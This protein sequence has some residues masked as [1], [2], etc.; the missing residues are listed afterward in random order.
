MADLAGR[1]N[2]ELRR[3]DGGVEATIRSSR[4]VAASRIFDGKG[5][6]ETTTALPA[7]FTICSAAQA[8]ACSSACEAALGLAPSPA[9]IRLRRLLVDAETVKEHLWRMLLDWPRF[10]GKPP[11][12]EAMQAVM[13]AYV[14]LR[15]ALTAVANPMPTAVPSSIMPTSR[16]ASRLT[17]TR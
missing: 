11:R 10:V 15:T 2:I 12:K 3:R 17:T 16:S 4:P 7:L 14:A 9:V 8:C 6:E 1:L 13:G 5:V